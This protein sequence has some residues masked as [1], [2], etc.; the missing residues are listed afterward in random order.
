MEIEFDPVKRRATLQARD[1]DMAD[2]GEVFEGPTLTVE[3]DRQ[4][5]GEA[6]YITIG[7]LADRMVVLVWTPRGAARRII[8]MRK[9]NDREQALYAPRFRRP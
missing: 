1:L 9:A 8:S 7:F 5:Y 2:A 3:D 4:D 6:R